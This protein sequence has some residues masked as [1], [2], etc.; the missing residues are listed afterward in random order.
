M[1]TGCGKILENYIRNEFGVKVRSVE[2]NVS[3]RCSGMLV[4]K[5]DIEEA[6]MAGSEGILAAL[7]GETGK[8]V[9]FFRHADQPY[10]MSCRMVD[11]NEVCNKEKIFP[12]EWITNH[13]T[14]ISP[15]FLNYV[16][17]LIEGEPERKIENGLPVYLYRK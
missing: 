1:L 3:Q 16:L 7:K 11:V 8:M 13:G 6:A 10:K 15:E 14:D 9:A 17:P 4:S 12:A 2:V 5:T